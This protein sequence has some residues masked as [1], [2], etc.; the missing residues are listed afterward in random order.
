MFTARGNTITSPIHHASIE[1]ERQTVEWKRE[2]KDEFLKEIASFAN[3]DGGV[4]SVGVDDDG[5]FVGVNDPKDVMKKISDTVANKLALYPS[6]DVDELT[7]IITVTVERS[8]VP[9][10]L[11]GRFYLRSGSTVHEARGREYD[12]IVAKRLN[13]SWLD[14]PVDG[15]GI[16]VL[17]SK[18]LR[19]FRER[20]SRTGI[21]SESSLSV[22]DED[23]L[24]K[25]GLMSNGNVTRAGILLFHPSP[26]DLI[27]GS[28]TKIGMFDG[29]EILYQD[30]VGGPLVDRLDRLLATLGSKYLVRPVT[31]DG[32]KRVEN[33]QYPE[34]SLRECIVNALAHNDYS[35]FNPVQI[36]MWS[37]RMMVS[38]SG[39]LPEDWT[40]ETLLSDHRSVPVNP[41]LAYAFFL[42]GYIENWGRGIE[43]IR[44]GYLDH[45]GKDVVFDAARSYFQV[46]LDAITVPSGQGRETPAPN[47]ADPDRMSRMRELLAFM[48]VP[49]GRGISEVVSMMGVKSK[50]SVSRNH[51]RPLM[52]RGLIEYTVP[53]KPASRNQRYRTTDLGRELISG[54]LEE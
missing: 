26:E 29:S 34:D 12:R 23:L 49:E 47:V 10:D 53:E 31:Y 54:N 38:D 13:I 3:T 2:W 36:R 7:G 6:V 5:R 8:P 46:T 37:D 4:I 40:M 16:D 19:G 25:L 20:T 14:M 18:A 48:D 33:T 39:G 15:M 30:V 45:V 21:L 22:S 28:F 44:S 35:S 51:L 41:K 32:W 11:N 43:R 17:D 42:M 24:T 9:V 50:S 27:T 52:A 1:M